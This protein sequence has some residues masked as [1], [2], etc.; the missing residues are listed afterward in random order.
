VYLSK[1][2]TN[3]TERS[4]QTMSAG[5]DDDDWTWDDQLHEEEK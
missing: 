1:K 2:T 5:D 4:N 3:Q